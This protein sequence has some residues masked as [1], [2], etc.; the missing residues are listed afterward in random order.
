MEYAHIVVAVIQIAAFLF[1]MFQIIRVLA[2]DVDMF[3]D[4]KHKLLW[5]IVVVLVPVVGALWFAVW[6]H[7]TIARR[8]RQ[9][10]VDQVRMIA[11][12]YQAE[13]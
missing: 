4:H 10:A 11:A 13:K 9:R 1:W 7:D 2:T 6:R 5:F 3:E 8:V 12:A